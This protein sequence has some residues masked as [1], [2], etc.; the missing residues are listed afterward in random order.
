MNN[1]LCDSNWV[2][3]GTNRQIALL[4]GIGANITYYWQVRA[5]NS[6]GL[7]YSDGGTWASFTT[8]TGPA[9]DSIDSAITLSIPFESNINTT[10]ATIDSGTTNACSSTLGFSSVWYKYTAPSNKRIYV[11]TF[12]S[13]YDTFIAVWTKNANGTL[14]PVTCND[15]SSGL[16]QS[17]L[18]LAVTSGTTYYIQVA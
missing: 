4:S 10:S 6:F 8:A 15:N 16:S 3:T 13:S 17:S 7:T 5:I 14:N 1:N 12:G 9:N 11:D 18:N 2:S